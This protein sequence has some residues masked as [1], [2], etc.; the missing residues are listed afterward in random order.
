MN[1]NN[2]EKLLNELEIFRNTITNAILYKRVPMILSDRA[3]E[4]SADYAEKNMQDAIFMTTDLKTDMWE[5]AVSKLKINGYIAEFGVYKGNSINYLANLLYPKQI[6]GFDSFFGLEEDFTIDYPK[7][8][9]SLNGVPPEVK[10]NVKLVIG[11]FSKSLP[12]WLKN[13]NGVFS[14]L[15]IDCDTYEATSTVLN[16]I[17]PDRIIPGTFILFDEYLGFHG[18]EKGEFKAWQDYCTK[19]NVKYK[20]VAVCHLQ[21]LVEVLP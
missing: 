16:L 3:V 11:S 18:W 14:F 4:N 19:N 6:F 9:F 7:G 20:Y 12:E 2:I 8:G 1:E 17:G 10:E 21:V 5:C 15:N 13:N